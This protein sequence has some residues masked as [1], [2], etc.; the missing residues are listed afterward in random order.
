MKTK[1][2]KKTVLAS[3]LTTCFITAQMKAQ[4]VV[5]D[6]ATF[7]GHYYS[8]M[9]M[10][11]EKPSGYGVKKVDELDLTYDEANNRLLGTAKGFE[12]K[13]DKILFYTE[14]T[15]KN[16]AQKSKIWIFKN[17]EMNRRY[18]GKDMFYEASAAVFIE[19]GVLVLFDYTGAVD[20]KIKSFDVLT[21]DVEIR[22]MAKDKSTLSMNKQEAA[23]RA[24]ELINAAGGE[25]MK[26]L[27]DDQKKAAFA[28]PK[29]TLSKTDK[30]IKA[31]VLEYFTN[32]QMPSDDNSTFI[33][34]YTVSPDWAIQK[35]TLTGAIL[36]REI[37]VEMVRRG[38]ISGKCRRFPYL[39]Y[40]SYNGSGYGKFTFKKK[41][42]IVEC[43][44]ADAEKNK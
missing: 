3:V 1:H 34:A 40:Q 17:G 4:L 14:Q 31:D 23:K 35:N 43:D 19:E 22:I 29:E 42:D 15:Q 9:K 6:P 30:A 10:E 11:V 27:L 33:C 5:V 37:V 24:D 2:V 13:S 12:S 7:S 38:N 36:G 21:S 28:F 32:L 39:L 16:W 20:D 41:W 25:Q 18:Y 44:C 26:K 8:E